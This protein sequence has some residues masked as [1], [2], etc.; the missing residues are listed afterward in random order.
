MSRVQGLGFRSARVDF[1]WWVVGGEGKPPVHVLLAPTLVGGWPPNGIGL[2]PP[3]R[4]WQLWHCADTCHQKP[5]AKHCRELLNVGVYNLQ[6]TP[7]IDPQIV[8]YLFQKEPNKVP[9]ES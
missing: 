2:Q 5:E 6:G 3:K 4:N 1:S 9:L 7:N 8:G